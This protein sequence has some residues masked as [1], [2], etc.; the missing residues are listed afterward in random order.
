MQHRR[1]APAACSGAVHTVLAPLPVHYSFRIA[2]SAL[3]FTV[4]SA[5]ACCSPRSRLPQQVQAA[6]S[7]PPPPAPPPQ[8]LRCHHRLGVHAGCHGSQ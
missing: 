2:S 1:W 3:D 4:Q 6:A 8:L 5:S 7:A